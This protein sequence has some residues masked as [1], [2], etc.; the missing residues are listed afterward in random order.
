MLTRFSLLSKQ[1]VKMLVLFTFTVLMFLLVDGILAQSSG[2]NLTIAAQVSATPGETVDV[3]ITFHANGTNV[4]SLVFSVDFD[5]YLTFDDTDNNGDQIPDAIQFMLPAGFTGSAT[6]DLNDTDGELDIVI[7]DFAPP[8]SSLPDSV[9]ANITFNTANVNVPTIATVNFSADPFPS[10]GSTTGSSLMG[11]T[12]NGSVFIDPNTSPPSSGDCLANPSSTT[13]GCVEL[14]LLGTLYTTLANVIFPPTVL[15]GNAIILES[16]P[17]TW[18]VG[19]WTGT[20]AG[21]HVMLSASGDFSDGLH[22]IPLSGFSISIPPTAITQ[23]SGTG[24]LPTTTFP[25]LPGGTVSTNGVEILSANPG[26]GMGAFD[27]VP[28]FQLYIPSTTVV[29]NYA[30]TLYV[31]IAAGP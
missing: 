20:N 18:S 16:N 11:T 31:T 12:T 30:T 7:A 5:T 22:S 6:V 13:E 3:P 26:A 19:D 4:A 14:S 10:F 2:P 27:F 24:A 15:S 25:T 1:N 21:W 28:T 9:I 17:T 23:T 8:L 29:G